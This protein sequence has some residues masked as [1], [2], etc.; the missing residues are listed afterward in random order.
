MG[1]E[2]K[3]KLSKKWEEPIGNRKKKGKRKKAT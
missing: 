1:E 3:G 2:T